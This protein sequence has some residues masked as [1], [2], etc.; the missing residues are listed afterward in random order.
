MKNSPFVQRPEVCPLHRTLQVR[1]WPFGS[2]STWHTIAPE[3]GL[4]NVVARVVRGAN[5]NYY[6]LEVVV[7]VPGRC[8]AMR[9]PVA[10]RGKW[11]DRV[12]LRRQCLQCR[13]CAATMD[14]SKRL[15][16]CSL[17][18]THARARR[19]A[20]FFGRAASYWRASSQA[21]GHSHAVQACPQREARFP[22]S[23]ISGLP[24]ETSEGKDHH[25]RIAGAPFY[26]N[27]SRSRFPTSIYL[28]CGWASQQVIDG[29]PRTRSR[30]LRTAFI[31]HP[32]D[33][34]IGGGFSE[35]RRPVE[36]RAVSLPDGGRRA[37]APWWTRM[38]T[39]PPARKPLPYQREKTSN[40]FPRLY[41]G[42]RWARG[43]PSSTESWTSVPNRPDR[44]RCTS[45]SVSLESIATPRPPLLKDE[46]GSKSVRLMLH[47]RLAGHEDGAPKDPWY[48]P[49]GPRSRRK[50]RSES[51]D[52]WRGAPGGIN[53]RR[54]RSR[55]TNCGGTYTSTLQLV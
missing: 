40:F 27:V 17:K 19:W 35:P 14:R 45:P 52:V 16:Y 30:R 4:R 32:P 46:Y 41:A 48:A 31:R 18:S 37:G 2:A 50:T 9:Y 12:N 28:L 43:G 36:D 42:M 34:R 5:W 10:L 53:L 51:L 49:P 26:R 20:L 7:T 15:L 22:R 29:G 24:T 3:T 33:P 38:G 6:F 23:M 8:S 21:L 11:A 39:R 54:P 47:Q 55:T 25:K 1:V 44:V 13:R